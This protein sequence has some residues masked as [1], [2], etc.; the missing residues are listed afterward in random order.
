MAKYVDVFLNEDQLADPSVTV[1]EHDAQAADIFVDMALHD[2]GI[3]PASV[4]LPNAILT[5]IAANWAKRSACV[6]GAIGDNSPLIDKAKQYES[7]ATVLVSMLNRAALGIAEPTGAAF[8][9]ITLGR[10]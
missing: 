4:T 8:G 5:E 7:Q 1:T 3:N 9:Q 10:A 6:Q 2:R